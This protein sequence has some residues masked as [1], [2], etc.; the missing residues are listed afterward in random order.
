VK[1][2]LKKGIFNKNPVFFRPVEIIAFSVA[3]NNIV[4]ILYL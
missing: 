3:K 1:A 2:I 4:M